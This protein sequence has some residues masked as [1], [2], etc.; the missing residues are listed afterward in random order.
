MYITAPFMAQPAEHTASGI[1]FVPEFYGTMK[2]ENEAN[3]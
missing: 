1:K 2:S 3:T